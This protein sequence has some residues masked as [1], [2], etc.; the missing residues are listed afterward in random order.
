MRILVYGMGPLG[1]VF[2][3]RLAEAGHEVVA[4]ARGDRLDD[5]REYGIVLEDAITA[6]RETWHVE[7]IDKLEKDDSYDLILVVMRKNQAIEILPTL[8]ANHS[9][10]TVLFMMSNISGFAELT[11][12][13]GRERVMVGFPLPGGEAHG[14]VMRIVPQVAGRPWELPI[15]EVDGRV[16]PRTRR[17]AAILESMRGYTVVIRTDMDAWLKYHSAGIM[18]LAAALYAADLSTDRLVRTPDA[19]ILG[20]RGL[21]EAFRGLREMGIPPSPSVGRVVAWLPEPM[22]V[23]MVGRFATMEQLQV[24]IV[25]HVRDA[26]DEM[27]YLMDELLVLLH[28][29]GI[30]TPYLDQ[31]YPYLDPKTPPIPDGSDLIGMNWR[32]VWLPAVALGAAVS[33]V[34]GLKYMH[35]NGQQESHPQTERARASR[36]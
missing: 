2:A 23:P 18:P 12:A 14:H 6:E 9:S 15:G 28:S 7:T 35:R 4:L 5:L 19:M 26:R 27:R 11:E 29:A 1:S 21:K 22:L 34:A 8:A 16:A 25:G 30:D 32:P 3:A 36:S 33:V 20:V 10:P 13:L 24:S 17:I 31:L